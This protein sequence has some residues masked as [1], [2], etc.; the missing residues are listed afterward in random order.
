MGFPRQEYWNGS[1]FLP[2]GDLPDP[3]MEPVSPAAPVGGFFTIEP[4]RKLK[5]LERVAIL[6]SRGLPDPG[7]KLKSPAL[8]GRCFTTEPPGK[9]IFVCTLCVSECILKVNLMC[10]KNR[11]YLFFPTVLYNRLSPA[12]CF[13]NCLLFHVYWKMCLF[14]T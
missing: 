12:I 2:P 1:P 11:L 4:P 13:L 3:G 10:P 9:P 14:S 7:I 5:I 8:A 6:F